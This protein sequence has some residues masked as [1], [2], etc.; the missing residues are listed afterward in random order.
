MRMIIIINIFGTSMCLEQARSLAYSVLNIKT[1]TIDIIS[2]RKVDLTFLG[3][4]S[5]PVIVL[6]TVTPD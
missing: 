3:F 5:M 1:H 6:D 2:A 4:Y